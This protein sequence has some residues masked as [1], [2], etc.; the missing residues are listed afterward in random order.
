MGFGLFG[1]SY[2]D[3]AGIGFLLRRY[4]Q[5][6]EYFEYFDAVLYYFVRFKRSVGR[7]GV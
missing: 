3:D 2:A 6:Q 1:I 5:T 7:F 4:G